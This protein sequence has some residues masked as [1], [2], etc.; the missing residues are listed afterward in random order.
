M[1]LEVKDLSDMK[2][3]ELL[4]AWQV[5]LKGPSPHHISSP[6]IRRIIAFEIQSRK[7]GGLPKTLSRKLLQ[8]QN[9]KKPDT[10]NTLA[11]GSRLIREW[12]GVSHIVDVTKDGYVWNGKS[13]KSLSAIARAI[14]GARWSGPRFFGLNKPGKK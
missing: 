14:T 11:P 5:I 7:Q 1:I 9:G 12:N 6:V 2:R 10:Q 4:M 8:I 3:P 13:F